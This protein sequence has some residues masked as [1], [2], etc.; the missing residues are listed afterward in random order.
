LPLIFAVFV[1]IGAVI[2][3]A[4]RLYATAA[5][6]WGWFAGIGADALAAV[7]VATLIALS[8]HRHRTIH[9]KPVGR[10]RILS[11]KGSWGRISVDAGQ[12]RGRL[13]LD[14]REAGFVFADIAGARPV[15]ENA[16][17]SVELRLRHTAADH[18]NIPMPNRK[19]ARRWAKILALAAAQ[20][21]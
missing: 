18:W 11:M 4:I 5:A 12:K 9:G 19:Q 14:D 17:W 6:R 3:G 7:L 10:E 2:Y 1:F 13:K 21:L 20:K 8:V 16:A 15:V